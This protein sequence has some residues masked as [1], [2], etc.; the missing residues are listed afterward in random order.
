MRKTDISDLSIK[1]APGDSEKTRVWKFLASHSF[2]CEAAPDSTVRVV[3]YG[4][5]RL[6]T[7]ADVALRLGMTTNNVHRVILLLEREGW[8]R[9]EPIVEA[10]GLTRGNVKILCFEK[11]IP[12]RGFHEAPEPEKYE[13]LPYELQIW[14]KRFRLARPE[15]AKVERLQEM[16]VN[17]EE[18]V[19]QFRL[20]ARS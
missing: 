1:P 17:L 19:Q 9:R 16:A 20:L 7:Q 4:K 2:L 14:L 18:S 13:G 12:T 8:I 10:L 11:P 6:V 3:L 5:V 15:E